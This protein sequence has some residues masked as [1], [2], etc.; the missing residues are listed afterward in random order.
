MSPEDIVTEQVTVR[1]MTAYCPWCEEGTV[2]P[3]A[4]T[5]E[6]PPPAV[7][8]LAGGELDNY[9]AAV[10]AVEAWRDT[11]VKEAHPAALAAV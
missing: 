3:F 1:C 5:R 6:T 4:R 11:H 8:I 7:Q 2:V 9:R 10:A